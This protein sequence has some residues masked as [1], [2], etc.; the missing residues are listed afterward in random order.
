MKLPSILTLVGHKGRMG[1]MFAERLQ[2][3]GIA[4]CG[5]DLP[6][7]SAHERGQKAG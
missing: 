5:L 7:P 1:A 4:V 6:E 2:K 3:A